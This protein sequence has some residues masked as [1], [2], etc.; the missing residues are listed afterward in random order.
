MANAIHVTPVGTAIYPWLNKPDTKFNPDGE[1]SVSLLLSEDAAKVVNN[2]VK[3]LMNGGKHNPIKPEVDDQGNGTGNYTIKFKL[4][5]KVSPKRGQPFEQKPILLDE[6]GNRLEKLIGGGSKIK[7]A[8]EAYA[9]D[10]M[11]GGVTLRVKKVRIAQD[12]L[13]EYTS[14]DNVDWGEDCVDKP[15]EEVEDEGDDAQE[16]NLVRLDLDDEDF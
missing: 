6:D 12:G 16:A 10:G 7:I 9:Y 2:V 4:K 14:K 11:G 13:V 5:A 8:Y 1:Y 3:P 15:K